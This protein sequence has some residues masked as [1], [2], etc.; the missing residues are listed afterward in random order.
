MFFIAPL[1]NEP[2]FGDYTELYAGLSPD[3]TLENNGAYVIPWG[4]TRPDEACPWRDII[5]A[6]I[7]EKYGGLG[8]TKKLWEWYELKWKPC[9]SCEGVQV[10][11]AIIHWHQVVMLERTVNIR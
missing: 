4:R 9:V 1:L 11:K 3:I 6:M 2:K 8:Y 7:T 10:P 5:T